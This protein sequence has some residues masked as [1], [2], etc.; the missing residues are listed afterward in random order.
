M[1]VWPA[2]SSFL[3]LPAGR[4]RYWLGVG[5]VVFVQ[6]PFQN[7]ISSH[8]IHVLLSVERDEM[9]P[10]VQSPVVSNY[11][12]VVGRRHSRLSSGDFQTVDRRPGE[13]V[14]KACKVEE[15][16]QHRKSCLI[17]FQTTIVQVVGRCSVGA[18]M[19]NMATF[20]PVSACGSPESGP[21]RGG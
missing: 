12:F 20:P 7:H 6:H 9:N 14:G 19:M 3:I 11:F 10:E 1:F 2:E 13:G 17:Y 15:T 8:Q 18:F 16:G 4:I 21:L 5:V